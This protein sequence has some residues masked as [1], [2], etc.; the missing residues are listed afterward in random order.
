MRVKTEFSEREN[1]KVKSVIAG[2]PLPVLSLVVDILAILLI[3]VHS[4]VA[5]NTLTPL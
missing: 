2:R 4:A 5:K 3:S 1:V